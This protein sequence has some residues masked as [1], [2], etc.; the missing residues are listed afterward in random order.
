M[1]IKIVFRSLLD[2]FLGNKDIIVKYYSIKI[3][4]IKNYYI[5]KY[6]QI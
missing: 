6:E 2:L 5:E 4:I 3:R 1:R